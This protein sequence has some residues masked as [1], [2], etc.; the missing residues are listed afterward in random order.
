M[1]IP[2]SVKLLNKK[3]GDIVFKRSEN[4]KVCSYTI[5]SENAKKK[6]RK[7]LGRKYY[8][9]NIKLDDSRR[10]ED[11]PGIDIFYK[12][13]KCLTSRITKVKINLNKTVF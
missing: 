7:S 3:F 8:E 6:Y 9:E 11:I 13:L 10:K 4:V 12:Y 5:Y 1:M 2:L